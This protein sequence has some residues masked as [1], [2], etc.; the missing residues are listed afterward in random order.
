MP[1]LAPDERAGVILTPTARFV[2]GVPPEWVRLSLTEL[3]GADDRN[4]L[5]T[6]PAAETVL[7]RLR[8]EAADPSK[9]HPDLAWPLPADARWAEMIFELRARERFA[10]TF[11]S[12]T[13]LFEPSDLDMRKGTN[14]QPNNQWILLVALAKA[15]GILTCNHRPEWGTVQKQ[16][17]LLG[18]TLSRAFGIQEAPIAWNRRNQEYVTRFVIRSALSKSERAVQIN[19]RVW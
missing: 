14:K 6:L 19:D 12:Q 8:Q 13:K 9:A 5:V 17:Q 7:A 18:K 16:V 15:G 4:D 1:D 2:D 10:V 3:V 11:R